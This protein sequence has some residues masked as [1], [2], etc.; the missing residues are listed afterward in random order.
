MYII[1]GDVV[2]DKAIFGCLGVWV[3]GCLGVWVFGCLGAWVL[4][5]L[6]AWLIGFDIYA[7]LSIDIAS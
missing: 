7:T 4:G 2:I 5:C 3:L 1:P 6:G